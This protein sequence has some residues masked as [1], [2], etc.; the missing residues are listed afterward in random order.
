M[1]FVPAPSD[2]HNQP[3]MNPHHSVTLRHTFATAL[4]S[5]RGAL[6]GSMLALTPFTQAADKKPPP[7]K[8]A[9]QYPLFETHEKEHVS[10]AADPC[11]TLE[12]CPFFR[13]P[14]IRHGFLPVRVIITNDADTPLDLNDVRIQFISEN[15]DIIPAALPE[16]LNRRLYS[17]KAAQGRSMPLPFPGAPRPHLLRRPDRQKNH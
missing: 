5:L 13:N 3:H 17:K 6:L 12:A 4:P 8:P 15:K 11:D 1:R 10:I 7:A 2:D 14:Y 16:D 9:T